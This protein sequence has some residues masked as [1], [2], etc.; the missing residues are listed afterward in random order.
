M[1]KYLLFCMVFLIVFSCDDPYEKDN[2]V[3]YDLD[4]AATYLESRQDEFSKWIDILK[5]A[6]LYNAVN[7]ASKSFTLFVPNNDAVD[8]FLAKKG[9]A[10]VSD[11]DPEYVKAL[12]QFHVIEGEISQKEFLIG[13]KLTK[14]TISGDY[15]SVSFDDSGNA[16]GGINSVYINDE[17]LVN[18]LANT[19]TNGFVYTLNDVLTPLVETVYDR[20]NE[21]ESYSIFKEAV[22]A[23]GW[24]ETLNT[25]YDTVQ[26]EYGGKTVLRKNYT[27]FVVS[28]STFGD[29][30]VSSL[31]DLAQKVEASTDYESPDNTLNQ[32]VAYHLLSSS[33]Y[34]T[35]LFSF[36]EGDSTAIWSTLAPKQ[37]LSTHDFSGSY[38]VNYDVATS[39]GIGLV[40]DKADMPAKNGVLHEVDN[41]MP[42]FAPTPRTVIWDVCDYDDVA[43]VVNEYGASQELGDIYQTAQSSEHWIAFHD[44]DAIES[45]YDV[46]VNST[47]AGYP[48]LGYLVTKSNDG[49]ATNTYGAYKN[50]M[51]V[52]N[53]GYLGTVSMK[54]PVLLKG[55]YKVE[56]YYASA[57]SLAPF[58]SGGSL[59]KVSLDQ[60]NN[61]VYV[62]DG[63]K[64]SVGI[65]DMALFDEVDLEETDSHEFKIVL[66]D[67]R[68]TTH[69]KYRLQLDYIKFTPIND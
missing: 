16:E 19:V 46:K 13:G 6:D 63:A 43:S 22:E 56:L 60:T 34:A 10:S 62:Y 42:V 15:L 8:A 23:T 9:V 58:V 30:G 25:V 51:L 35:D 1:K 18:E 64:A 11:L 36:S 3:V 59:C 17:A 20:L 48:Q 52:V 32:Y 57:G 7:Q 67:S 39:S 5:Y 28:N 24:D 65:Y 66:L 40:S 41:Y 27:M 2:F 21:N 54:T 47:S 61:E 26:T 45:Y 14:T 38:Y 50:D 37:V 55:K 4:P 69:N 12:V 33:K 31:D 49:G 29:A 53:L 68:A 44:N